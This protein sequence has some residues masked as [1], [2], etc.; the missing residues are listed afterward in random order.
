MIFK[1]NSFSDVECWSRSWSWGWYLSWSESG[2]RSD[3]W[4]S[5]I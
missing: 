4:S 5:R 2:S 3:N 1:T